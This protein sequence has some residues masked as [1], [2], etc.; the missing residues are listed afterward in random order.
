MRQGSAGLAAYAYHT[1]GWRTAAT[2]G[3]RRPVR[4]GAYLRVCRR[5]LLSR[6]NRRPEALGAGRDHK[7]GPIHPAVAARRR[8]RRVNDRT[9]EHEQLLRR[10]QETPPESSSARRHV[11]DR[12]RDRDPD[13]PARVSPAHGCRA[14]RRSHLPARLA[15]YLHDVPRRVPAI[16]W[17]VSPAP[18]HLRHYVAVE[19]ALEAL[20]ART[21]RHLARRTALHGRPAASLPFAHSCRIA[22]I[23]RNHHAVGPNFLAEDTRPERCP[24][25]HG[26]R[27]PERG[28][29]LRRLLHTHIAARQPTQ[30]SAGKAT[31]RPGPADQSR[32]TR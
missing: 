10:L 24:A 4:L 13:R 16:P 9:S 15:Q 6:R 3:E 11:R 23:D 26:P 25:S 21:R 7:L 5:V 18:R 28:A 1:L 27:H 12:D 32:S 2:F 17:T 29:T 14:S 22:R 31:S 20:A 19:L 8:R 30:P